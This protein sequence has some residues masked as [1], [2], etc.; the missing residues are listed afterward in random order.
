MKSK[1]TPPFAPTL[2][3]STRAIGYSLEAAIADIV[4]NSIA[5]KSGKVQIS[6]FPIGDAYVCILDDG[7]GTSSSGIWIST[8]RRAIRTIP[9][10]SVRVLP[11]STF[12]AS[13]RKI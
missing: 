4:D 9:P 2:M 7:A 8:P 11:W 1:E 3:E 10:T 5:A 12:P 6:F 13:R